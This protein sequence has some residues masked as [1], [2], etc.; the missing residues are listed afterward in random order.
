MQTN[1]YTQD[2]YLKVE[3]ENAGIKMNEQVL[4]ATTDLAEALINERQADWEYQRF[5]AK[6]MD[7]EARAMGALQQADEPTA[8]HALLRKMQL[9][10]KTNSFK[11]TYENTK[12]HVMLSKQRLEHLKTNIDNTAGENMMQTALRNLSVLL[13]DK[14]QQKERQQEKINKSDKLKE[15]VTPTVPAQKMHEL[16]N[17]LAKLKAR[18]NTSE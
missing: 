7:L 18:V 6:V 15:Q 10:A 14:M 9:E 3:T 11:E 5:H 12:K 1:E 2:G 8:R 16:E 13:K 4:R 17:M